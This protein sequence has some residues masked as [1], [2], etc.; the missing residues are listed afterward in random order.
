[1]RLLFFNDAILYLYRNAK[2]VFFDTSL[3]ISGVIK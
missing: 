2:I 3:Q 1:L